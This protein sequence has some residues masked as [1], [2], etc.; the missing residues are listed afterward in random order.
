MFQKLVRLIAGMP[1]RIAGYFRRRVTVM[2]VPHS[3]RQPR[4]VQLQVSAVLFIV[5]L[6]GIVLASFVFL[7]GAGEQSVQSAA[8]GG[9]RL[10]DAEASLEQ[11]REEVLYFLQVYD[12][13][14]SVLSDTLRRVDGE[15][16]QSVSTA[17]RADLASLLRTDSLGDGQRR[18]IEK[19]QQ[20]VATL[21]ASIAPLGELSE[22]L[23]LHNELLADLPNLWP[24]INGLGHITM[25]FG[26][27]IHPF[28]GVWYMHRG[29][30][31]WYYPGTPI[32]AAGNGVVSDVGFDNISGFGWFVEIDHPYGFR[33]K[34]THLTTVSVRRGQEV[35]QGERIGTLGSSGTATGPHLHFEIHLGNELIDPAYFLKLSTPGLTRRSPL[36]NATRPLR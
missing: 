14:T 35:S 27:N 20:A 19:L 6:A 12:E 16:P 7:V 9:A 2:V 24:V 28:T 30:D 18:Q 23:E 26:P 21:R 32:I 15:L 36:I 1:L 10:R 13:F 25:E 29:L 22:A 8:G 4:S 31:I 17:P 5:M 3:D 34:Y 33:T 11:I